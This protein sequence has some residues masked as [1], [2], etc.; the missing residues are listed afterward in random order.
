MG[1]HTLMLLVARIMRLTDN[2]DCYNTV[3]RPQV[4]S[5]LSLIHMPYKDKLIPLLTLHFRF[6]WQIVATPSFLPVFGPCTLQKKHA[7]TSL[8]TLHQL[9]LSFNPSAT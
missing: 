5:S 1:T 6:D 9:K 8:Y 4:L 3:Q 7:Y 2:V